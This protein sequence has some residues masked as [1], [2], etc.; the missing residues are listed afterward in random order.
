MPPSP[1]REKPHTLVVAIDGPAGA[2]KS[3]V[4]RMLASRL[5]VPYLD[6]GAMYR[7]VGLL[8]IRNG[9]SAPLAADDEPALTALAEEHTIELAT[10]G[11]GVAV[12]VF[13]TASSDER[14]RRRQ[15]DLQ[16]QG[17][18]TTVD[19]VK[20]QQHQRDLQDTSR[21][22]SP[23]HVAEGS[24]VVDT[25]ASSLDEVVQRLLAELQRISDLRLDTTGENTI[26]SRNHGGLV[27]GRS[28]PI[29]EES[30]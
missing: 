14:A 8:A 21:A 5:G 29:E 18:E 19:E 15:L 11:D 27:R 16:Q 10:E 3:T 30:S 28:A 4:A 2:G 26:R 24:V 13:L 22:D 23:L 7:A 12:K 6:T 9:I 20:R 1:A 25:T 17:I